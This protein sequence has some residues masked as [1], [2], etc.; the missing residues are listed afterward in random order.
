VRPASEPGSYIEVSPTIKNDEKSAIKSW[1]RMAKR[2]VFS[3]KRPPSS[4]FATIFT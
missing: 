4:F 2:I 3:E 1:S